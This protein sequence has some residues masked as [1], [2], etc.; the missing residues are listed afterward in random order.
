MRVAALFASWFVLAGIVLST[1]AEEKKSNDGFHALFTGKNLKGWRL[2]HE[3]SAKHPSKWGVV[4]GVRL[5]AEKPALFGVS[6][7][8]GVLVNEDRSIDLLTEE[9]HG[10]C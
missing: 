5:N 6:K 4:G 10:D 7:G 8:D 2:R 3:A 1:P 9:V